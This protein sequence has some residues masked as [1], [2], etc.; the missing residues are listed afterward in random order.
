MGYIFYN[1]HVFH[2]ASDYN[3]KTVIVPAIFAAIIYTTDLP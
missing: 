1:V 3:N 2:S